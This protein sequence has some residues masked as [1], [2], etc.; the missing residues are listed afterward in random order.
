[1]K[2]GM[3]L[4]GGGGHGRVVLDTAHTAGLDVIGIVDPGHAVGETILGVPVI[5]GDEVLERW[6]AGSGWLNGIGANPS[7]TRRRTVFESLF[8]RFEVVQ[9]RHPSAIIGGECR[10][11]KGVQ[12]MAGTILQTGSAIGEN[13]VINTGASVD[14]DCQIGAHCFIG[15]R[16]TLC[17]QVRIGE[18]SFVGAGAVILP[19]VQIG[20]GAVIGAGALV[21]RDVPDGAQVRGSPARNMGSIVS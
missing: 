15:P 8:A 17:G 16:A 19:G 2:D 5:G 9:L 4:V 20:M 10:L 6:A 21:N 7:L 3:Y 12:L 18:G 13:T 14:H 1:M 11:G